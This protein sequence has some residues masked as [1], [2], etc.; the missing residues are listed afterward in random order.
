MSSSCPVISGRFIDEDID[1]AVQDLL[2]RQAVS[3]DPEEKSERGL[4]FSNDKSVK[5][6]LVER[7]SIL[8]AGVPVEF[9][10]KGKI[11]FGN[12]L[13]HRKDS[14][15]LIVK[16]VTGEEVVIDVAQVISVWED[17]SDDEPPQ[18]PEDWAAVTA[19]AVEIL[20]SMSP[21]KSDLQEFWR[22]NSIFTSSDLPVDS[23][24]LGVY[25]FQERAFKRWM[26]PDSGPNTPIYALTAAQRYVAAIILSRDDLHFKRRP[27]KVAWPEDIIGASLD[28]HD[29]LLVNASFVVE[30]GYKVLEESVTTFKEAEAFADYYHRQ[31]EGK[32]PMAARPACITRQ[33]R[34]LELVSLHPD[35]SLKPIKP[36][37]KKLGKEVSALA[38]RELLMEL[39]H[40]QL[41][42]LSKDDEE[43][44]RG[45][46]STTISKQYV[47]SSSASSS[48][49]SLSYI[50]NL[51]PWTSAVIDAANA[52]R[53]GVF[54]RKEE[55]RLFPVSKLGKKGWQGRADLRA[56]RHPVLCLDAKYATFFDDAYSL[57]PE[58]GEILVHVVD[59]MGALRKGGDEL[60]KVAKERVSTA[61]LPAGS[62][63]MLP[64]QALE[65]LKLSS[66]LPNE[67]ITVA[68][69]VDFNTGEILG[70]RVLA[71]VINP[72]VSISL[73]RANDILNDQAESNEGDLVN[74]YQGLPAQAISDL[75]TL[76]LLVERMTTRQPWLL[77]NVQGKKNVENRLNRRRAV[78]ERKE[79]TAPEAH[80]I[81]NTCLSLYSNASYHFCLERNVPVPLAWENRDKQNSALP[82]RFAT[83]PLRNWISQLQQKQI[84]SAMNMDFPLTK[85]E[86]ALAVAYHNT[87]R[88]QIASLLMK[89]R[90][91]QSFEDLEAYCMTMAGTLGSIEHVVM[92][93]EGIGRGGHVRLLPFMVRG[94]VTNGNIEEGQKVQVRVKKINSENK[95][96]TLE[97]V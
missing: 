37:L 86:C 20:R 46:Y 70:S 78:I 57:S 59:V 11:S 60:M 14:N 82:R 69:S 3:L 16:Q 80:N 4:G 24:D 94:I 19:E 71:T 73:D 35:V 9:F 36:L 12:Y 26:D 47:A 15:A 96:V 65:A 61:F 62:S 6:R 81:I 45:K 22:L 27:S 77:A 8:S 87:K 42:E 39:G 75:Q 48:S 92:E 58:T 13:S 44:G 68:I 51:T 83:Q 91:H 50:R 30:G 23:L 74:R 76:H 95:L 72:V 31:I 10:N 52:L 33:L 18:T 66:N 38:A 67:A 89:G 41:T 7:P 84:R 25:I 54:K 17:L 34:A 49:P 29:P 28:I 5:R 55:L 32:D 90:A 88:K 63:H 64:P 79:S 40:G 93:A 53:Q 85:D 97:L 2:Y 56:S 21:R 1:Q 43:K